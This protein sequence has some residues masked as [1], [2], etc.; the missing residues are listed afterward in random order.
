M[1]PV[2]DVRLSEHLLSVSSDGTLTYSQVIL[3][4]DRDENEW[5]DFVRLSTENGSRLVLT[6]G[7]LIYAFDERP[8]AT[9]ND[10]WYESTRFA[11]S[12][13]PGHWIMVRSRNGLS[14]ERVSDVGAERMSGYYAP[15]T[16]EGNVVVNGVVASC[17]AIIENQKFAHA[18]FGPFRVW[19]NAKDGIWYAWR[20][21]SLL[22]R[23]TSDVIDKETPKSRQKGIHLYAKFLYFLGYYILPENYLFR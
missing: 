17:Y 12:V 9:G 1:V 22:P 7:H 8:S 2:S 15:L 13:R 4:L 21:L 18:A 6:P 23:R 14:Y 11:N 19:E 5:R 20:G 10:S 3:F 16:R